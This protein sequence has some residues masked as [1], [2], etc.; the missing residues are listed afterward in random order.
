[1]NLKNIKDPSYTTIY[2]I[3]SIVKNLNIFGYSTNKKAEL[4]L[5]TKKNFQQLEEYGKDNCIQNDHSNSFRNN[6]IC[7]ILKITLNV[8]Y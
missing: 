8:Y 4:E 1:M 5:S 7:T 2:G 6:C 3:N